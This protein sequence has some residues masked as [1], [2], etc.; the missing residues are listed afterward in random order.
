MADQLYFL[1]MFRG[2]EPEESLR[3]ILS[4]LVITGAEL[5]QPHRR[6]RLE[7]FS[8]VYI[9]YRYIDIAASDIA[10]EYVLNAL[11]CAVAYP[12]HQLHRIE[13]EELKWMFVGENSMFR[14]SLAGAVWEWNGNDLT[15]RLRG[16]GKKELEK[17]APKI[18]AQLKERF[19]CDVSIS[20]EAGNAL[21]GKALFEAMDR[22][23]VEKIS[24]FPGSTSV[25]APKKDAP[26]APVATD[27]I[28]G[29]S[30]RG[31]TVA[32][33]DIDLNMGNVIVEGRVFALDH[34]DLPKRNA[35]VVKFDVTDN[36]SSIRV[37]RFMEKR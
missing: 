11:E 19:G 21:E 26:A 8:E 28:F 20:F 14:G 29:K 10:R 3:Q 9:P 17:A 23:R 13:P 31:N 6:I 34:K 2:Y 30:F 25:E 5:D 22:L 18:C 32:M 12:E 7:L 24:Q 36:T 27:V 1:D 16:N 15:V 35:V 37:S 4:T 33:K